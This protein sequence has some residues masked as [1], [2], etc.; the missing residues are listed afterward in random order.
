MDTDV[1]VH[2]SVGRSTQ[3]K[4]QQRDDEHVHECSPVI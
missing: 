2:L 3:D 4:C 1:D